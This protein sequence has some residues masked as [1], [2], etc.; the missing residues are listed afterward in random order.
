MILTRKTESALDAFQ[1][2][3]PRRLTGRQPRRGRD[4]RWFYPSLARAMKEAGVVRIRTSILR[5]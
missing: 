5:R 3:V 4:E 1:V 2:R